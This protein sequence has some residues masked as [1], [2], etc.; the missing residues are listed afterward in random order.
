MSKISTKQFI[1]ELKNYRKKQVD[2]KPKAWMTTKQ[3]AEATGVTQRKAREALRLVSKAGKLEVKKFVIETGVT[4]I[5]KPVI[6]FRIKGRN[7]M[8]EIIKGIK[9]EW[10]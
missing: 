8:C 9:V 1:E 7:D 2:P 10:T 5:R 6:H 4:R 3:I